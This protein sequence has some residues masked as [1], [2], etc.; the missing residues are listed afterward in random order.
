MSKKFV[1]RIITLLFLAVLLT[2]CGKKAVKEEGA[3]PGEKAEAQEQTQSVNE[4]GTEADTGEAKGG[5]ED[6][7]VG[8][9][10]F[11]CSLYHS[12]DSEGVYD[13]CTMST[14]EESPDS[15][16]IIRRDGDKLL[17]DY[18]FAAYE[19]SEKIYGAEL[20][21]KEEAAYRDAQNDKWCMEMKDPFD[22]D[23]ETLPVRFSLRDD[24]VLVASTEHPMDKSE[25]YPFYSTDVNLYMRKGSPE[26]KDPD[27]LR[28]FDTV[29]V[30]SAEELL[31]NIQNNRKIIVSS[32]EYNFS[33]VKEEKVD[34]RF[35]KREYGAYVITGVNN[36]C[37]E[38]DKN[39]EVL[40]CI[41][42]AYDRV[43]NFTSGRN[44]KLKGITAGHNV[45]PGYCSGSV[46]Y[47]NDVSGVDIEDCH[48]YGSGT[49]GIEADYSYNINVTG[50]EIYEC[51][52]GLIDFRNTGVASFKNC[53]LRDSSELS[54]ININDGYEVVFED[55][56]FSNNK[57]AYDSNYFVNLGEYDSVTFK[58]CSFSNNE[59][60]TF[61]NREVTMEDCTYDNNYAAFSDLIRSADPQQAL[62]KDTILDN[63]KKV[64]KKQEEIDSKL[65]SDSLMDQM[66]LNKTSYE[67][68]EM[69][70]TLLNQVWQ[71]I[72]V[73]LEEKELSALKDEQQKWIKEK[74]SA[75]KAAG[76][77]FEGGS[78]QPMVEYGAGSAATRK[79][80][81]ML[82]EK[83][84]K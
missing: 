43:V 83:Y 59:F 65:N 15:A 63:Y 70:D 25:E 56:E 33:E 72:G 49:Y 30:S 51:T 36:L 69:W 45:E 73:T 19:T 34:N 7:M 14:D 62:D 64:L 50:T 11:F 61:S 24:G 27:N 40:F 35:V 39:A 22:D 9:W 10:V 32:G 26:L 29:T 48:L 44:I 6:S 76:A 46:L 41:N 66:T 55:C 57:C 80:V 78:M 68:F 52:Y 84:V 54:M 60:V 20:V 67:E 53:V 74:E 16:L 2:S 47:Y 18:K 79:R 75:M 37:I 3:E 17:A 5:V 1:C 42:E 81:E 8:E 23:G 31:N 38:A 13:N 82:I 4:A 71:Y 77:D 28:Y 12:E 58:K 21:Y